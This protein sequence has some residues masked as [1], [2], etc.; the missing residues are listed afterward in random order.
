MLLRG[1]Y[2]EQRFHKYCQIKTPNMPPNP[3][4]W[5]K[6]KSTCKQRL[7]LFSF[8]ITSSKPFALDECGTHETIIAEL[9]D[10]NAPLKVEK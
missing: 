1:A 8:E 10:E 3:S 9:K 7:K 6:A 2:V 4:Y 5:L